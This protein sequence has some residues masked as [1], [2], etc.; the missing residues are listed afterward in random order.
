[1]E[2]SDL[3]N[4]D[5]VIARLK[6]TSKK[7]A[8]Q[9]LSVLAANVT[10]DDSQKIF[11]LLLDRERLGSTGVGHGVAIPH[12][13]LPNLDQHYGIFARLSEGVDFD[14]VDDERVD[15]VFLLLAPENAGADHLKA[16]ALIS[17]R[18]RDREFCNKL[19][20]SNNG[21]AVFA[22]LTDTTSSYA[23]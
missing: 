5:M 13:R 6:V 3:L 10:G 19:R 21:E 7:Q 11:A 17:R 16:L 22:L 18:M 1:M 4:L 20:G 15:L 23:A 12:A 2:I 9:E 8:L 14:S